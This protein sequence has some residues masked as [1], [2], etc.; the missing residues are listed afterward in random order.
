M[1]NSFLLILP[2]SFI[3]IC[4]TFHIFQKFEYIN[5]KDYFFAETI[6]QAKRKVIKMLSSAILALSLSVD[7]IGIG[8]AYGIKKIS[9]SKSGYIIISLMSFMFMLFSLSI[10]KIFAELIPEEISKSIGTIILTSLGIWIIYQGIKE[11]PDKSKTLPSSKK[12]ID[13]SENKKILSVL[14]K[15][16]GI[17]VEIIRT[18]EYCDIDKSSVIDAKESFYLGLALSIDSVG[19][20]I[21]SA[22]IG[23]H[24]FFLPLYVCLFQIILLTIGIHIGK[25]I[26]FKKQNNKICPIISG[27]ILILVSLCRYMI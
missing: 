24:S 19:V 1:S 15:S 20:G 5:R 7:S 14:I 11:N 23:L 6:I 16:L 2:I 22:I 12:N 8:I 26:N 10:G 21:S 17:T 27:G 18:P 13:F 3:Y 25:K 9:I 4:F